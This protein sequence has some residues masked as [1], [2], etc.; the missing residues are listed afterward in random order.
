MHRPIRTRYAG[1]LVPTV[2]IAG[3]ALLIQGCEQQTGIFADI[4]RETEIANRNLSKTAGVSGVAKL[5]DSY[6]ANLGSIWKLTLTDDGSADGEWTQTK[7]PEGLSGST[8]LGMAVVHE[9]TDGPRLYA[10]FSDSSP[11]SSGEPAGLYY[12]DADDDSWKMVQ[13]GYSGPVTKLFAFDTD[14]ND[15]N[16]QL[17][18]L[19][20]EDG[21]SNVFSLVF[22]PEGP[23]STKSIAVN[24]VIDAAY[25]S[26]DGE[27]WFLSKSYLYRG[28]GAGDMARVDLSS[29]VSEEFADVSGFAGIYSRNDDIYVATQ[30]GDVHRRIGGSWKDKVTLPGD[31]TPTPADLTVVAELGQ[32]DAEGTLFVAARINESNTG[33]GYFTASPAGTVTP[34]RPDADDSYASADLSEAEVLGFHVFEQSFSGTDGRLLFARTANSGLW[35]KEITAEG[36]Q[37]WRWE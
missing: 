18:A 2:L 23:G 5:E 9:A 15:Q 35:S 29:A 28:T 22:D 33:G 12:R 1:L 8:V 30:S 10:S 34:S 17:V 25:L 4:E 24:T 31:P 27:Y 36:P 20:P 11:D 26:G 3:F 19:S 16:D 6:Y 32:S 37:D 21:S 13:D 7:F 14:D